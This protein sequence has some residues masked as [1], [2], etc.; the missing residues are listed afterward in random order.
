MKK[1]LCIT[2]LLCMFLPCVGVTA[3]ATE[4]DF[5]AYDVMKEFV[6][7]HPYRKSGTENE[8]KAGEYI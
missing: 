8:K 2:L 7:L 6:S 4:D 1:I 5:V 3:F